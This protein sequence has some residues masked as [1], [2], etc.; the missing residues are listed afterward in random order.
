[1]PNL[2]PVER[3]SP[4]RHT[5]A[6]APVPPPLAFVL[7]LFSGWVNRNQEAVMDDLLEEN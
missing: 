4:V 6:M 5:P 7:L 2:A 3:R 1:M